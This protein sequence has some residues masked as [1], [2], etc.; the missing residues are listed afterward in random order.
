MEGLKPGR[1][2]GKEKRFCFVVV[3]FELISGHSCFHV[4]CTCIEFFGEV[5][6]FM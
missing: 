5:G 3:Q 6:H 4:V 1:R 2:E